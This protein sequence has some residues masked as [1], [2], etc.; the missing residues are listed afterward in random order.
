M[1]MLHHLPR[2]GSLA[3]GRWAEKKAA[4]QEASKDKHYNVR[5]RFFHLANAIKQVD[6][7]A[8]PQDRRLDPLIDRVTELH[9]TDDAVTKMQFMTESKL[10]VAPAIGHAADGTLFSFFGEPI[11]GLASTSCLPPEAAST[12]RTITNEANAAT[13]K[14]AA[15]KEITGEANAATEKATAFKE[16]TGDDLP[17]WLESPTLSVNDALDRYRKAAAFKEIT[18]DDLP[19]W[20]ES[21]TIS[22]N[23]ALDRYLAASATAVTPPMLGMA[24]DSLNEKAAAFNRITGVPLPDY[25]S[26]PTLSLQEAADRYFDA[27]ASY[28]SADDTPVQPSTAY[29]RETSAANTETLAT[30][31]SPI[32]RLPAK[33]TADRAMSTL[34]QPSAAYQREA[35]AVYQET[36]ATA[37]SY[38][39]P[40]QA[41][42]RKQTAV[43]AEASNDEQEEASTDDQENI[44]P[45]P[46]K[47]KKRQGK[48]AAGKKAEG[49]NAEGDDDGDGKNAEGGD[50]GDGDD[51]DGF[52]VDA[53][54]MQRKTDAWRAR[55]ESVVED[56]SE[57]DVQ[58]LDEDTAAGDSAA[59]ASAPPTLPLTL[60]EL[61]TLFATADLNRE[62]MVHHHGSLQSSSTIA[63]MHYP[64][65]TTKRS[66][67]NQSVLDPTNPCIAWLLKRFDMSDIMLVDYYPNRMRR[68]D[69]ND[70]VWNDHYT[71]A[72]Q[73]VLEES[74]KR[75]WSDSQA[76]TG[77]I[78]GQ[79][80]AI[81][82]KKLIRNKTAIT[83]SKTKTGEAQAYIEYK[84]GQPTRL[85]FL[86][87]HPEAHLCSWRFPWLR[88]FMVERYR[89][90]CSVLYPEEPLKQMGMSAHR[91]AGNLNSACFAAFLNHHRSPKKPLML[92]ATRIPP[93]FTHGLSLIS[94]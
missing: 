60:D 80:N 24:A 91:S 28:A 35:F 81:R 47:D 4:E 92:G 82:Y 86:I 39:P 57:E 22:L 71:E 36:P 58:D 5:K 65:Y 25:L 7:V 30:A 63:L 68:R 27:L 51:H 76:T 44:N 15:S 74:F 94:C 89:I 53:A 79:K 41:K 37:E 45:A 75:V 6:V 64:T 14:A 93:S 83:L 77:L 32:P 11:P 85:T 62:E 12:P 52:V 78:F 38:T 67:H 84:D 2:V 69:I 10:A 17:D 19:E 33:R 42:P 16:I 31:G 21:P 88:N 23:D 50:D 29:Q 56:I 70:M 18:C 72:S 43:E 61:R 55:V 66:I 26:S 9:E 20:L 46:S 1:S 3:E 13:E 59:E 34:P 54:A 49:K 40:R 90:I 48:N 8:L 87:H 73:R